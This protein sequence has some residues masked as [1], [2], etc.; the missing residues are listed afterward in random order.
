MKQNSLLSLLFSL[1][2]L[3]TL[4]Q[5]GDAAIIKQLNQDWLNAIMQEDS[6]SL[7]KILADD[8][9]LINP[10]GK[11]RTKAESLLNLRVPGQQ[12]TGIT[13]D[14]EDLRMLTDYTGI[15]TVWTTNHISAGAEKMI[16]KICYMDI[17]QKKNENWEAVAAHV[18][19]LK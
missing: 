11:R 17:Y 19:L 18:S 4:A 1:F 8:F 14:S 9:I 5:S 10:A 12:V 13:I 6:V 7:A 15:I 16:F 3:A 2:S